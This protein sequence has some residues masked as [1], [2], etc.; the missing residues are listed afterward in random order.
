MGG[1]GDLSSILCRINLRQQ[2]NLRYT[3]QLPPRRIDGASQYR[4]TKG[5]NHKL[6]QAIALEAARLMYERVESEASELT[7]NLPDENWPADLTR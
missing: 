7:R 4:R 1:E 6:R 2:T 3:A 5:M